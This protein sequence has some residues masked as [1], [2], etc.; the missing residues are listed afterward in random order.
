MEVLVVGAG[1][2]GC[3]VAWRLQQAGV[4]CTVL[5]RSVPG[6]EASSA[7]G[8]ILAPQAEAD[9]PG[10]F[11][12]LCL[13]SRALYP[14]FARELAEASDVDIAFREC[15][16]LEV[17]FDDAERAAMQ[18]RIAWQRARGLEATLA[19]RR[20]GARARARALA[21]RRRRGALPR[22][23]A[24]DN[25]LLVSALTIAA[26][27]AGARFVTAQAHGLLER[28]GRWSA[29][30]PARAS[31]GGTRCWWP[32]ARGPDSSPARSPRPR[33]SGRAGSDGDGA[34]P[35]ANLPTCGVRG[36][37]VRSSPRRWPPPAREHDG[38]CRLRQAGDRVRDSPRC[39]RRASALSGDCRGTRD[40]NVGRAPAHT[41]DGLPVLGAAQVPGLFLASGHFRNG[42]LLTPITATVL[43][44][45]ILGKPALDRP[46]PVPGRPEGA[47]TVT[48]VNGCAGSTEGVEAAPWQRREAKL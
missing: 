48:V 3:A 11:L 17:T 2:V 44:E 18:A 24:V 41:P 31:S 30:P 21:R 39:S 46:R 28:G 36:A 22:D 20:G 5:E 8:G 1:V 33:R 13:A 27:R 10:P 35:G 14:T 23:A 9:G 4:R 34:H 42:I 25:R 45:T 29:S 47:Y 15:G 43:T 37:R 40:R 32:Q 26:A 6:A 7:A 12:D 38:A 16:V 19:R